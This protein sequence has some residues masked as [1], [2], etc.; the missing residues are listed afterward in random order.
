MNRIRTAVLVVVLL[1]ATVTAQSVTDGVLAIVRGDHEAAVRILS[2]YADDAKD[3][4]PLAA[5]FLATLFHS[6]RVRGDDNYLRTC[7]LYQTAA[8]TTGSPVARQAELLLRDLA[9]P[10]A[11]ALFWELCEQ[12]RRGHQN[13]ARS[14]Q[15]PSALQEARSATEAGIAAFIR[16]DYGVAAQMLAPA[17]ED[18]PPDD[19]AAS[20][21]MGVMYEN[22]LGVVQDDF[23]AC[24]MYARGIR[25]GSSP[26]GDWQAGVLNGSYL[27]RMPQTRFQECL[28][29]GGMLGLHHGFEPVTITV[30]P[31]YWVS[32]DLLGVTVSDHGN[33]KRF[34]QVW[35]G[36]GGVFLP[37]R[38]TQ[39]LS[40]PLRNQRRNCI[41]IAEWLPASEPGRWMLLWRLYEVRGVELKDIAIE[42]LVYRPSRPDL[43][44]RGTLEDFVR[45]EVN[46]AGEPGWV[47][48]ARR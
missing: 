23:R 4:D 10:G 24:A 37:V 16:K 29:A 13:T 21:F 26:V 40:G 45:L 22:G 25:P 3:P 42:E 28:L 5:F 2:P 17:A 48:L 33:E 1:P 15:E 31:G 14:R 34:E 18:W 35:A 12:S 19:G 44:T 9:G 6:G 8:R 20:F 7:G 32:I 11:T 27:D 30:E 36:P 43:T 38:Y 41:E 47:A 46:D 39:L